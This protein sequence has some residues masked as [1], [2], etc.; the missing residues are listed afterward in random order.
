MN[1]EYVKAIVHFLEIRWWRRESQSCSSGFNRRC[2]TFNNTVRS[3]RLRHLYKAS[4]G[5]SLS[6]QAFERRANDGWQLSWIRNHWFC[7][8]QYVH[9]LVSSPISLWYHV[10]TGSF[11]LLWWTDMYLKETCALTARE[12]TWNSMLP[13]KREKGKNW[14]IS[15]LSNEAPLNPISLKPTRQVGKA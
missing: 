3:I 13:P 15:F 11:L 14:F 9:K 7:F 5:L 8:N 6:K 4:M 10:A 1:R 2:K 12:N